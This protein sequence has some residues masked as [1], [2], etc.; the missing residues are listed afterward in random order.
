MAVLRQARSSHRLRRASLRACALLALLAMVCVAH[1]QVSRPLGARGSMGLGNRNGDFF[2]EQDDLQVKVPG[3]YARI[4]RDFDGDEWTFNRQWSGLGNPSHN[5]AKYPSLGTF[6]T[7][8]SIDG[9]RTCDGT[10][11]AGT[12]SAGASVMMPGDISI[13]TVRIP[14]D[15]LMGRQ[16]DGSPAP[17]LG[18]QQSIARKGVGF[19]RSSDGLSFVSADHPR[20]VVRKQSVLVLPASNGPDAH[21]APGRPGQGGLS[22]TPINGYRW[23][24]RSGEWIEYDNFGRITSYGDRNDARVWMQYGGHGQIERVLD[25]NGRTVFTLLYKDGGK[26]ITEARDHT[27]A[28]GSIRRVQYQYDGDGRLRTVVDAR[29]H[30]TT[31]DYGKRDGS[32]IS[33]DSSG[34]PGATA[35]SGTSSGSGSAMVLPVDLRFQIVKVTDAEGRATQI[36]YDVTKRAARITAPDGG[37]T[38]FEYGYDRLKSEFSIAIK[39]PQTEAGRRI[40]TLKFDKEGRPVQR[41]VNGKTV[42]TTQGGDRAMTYVDE[43]GASTQVVRDNFDE[44]TRITYA[45]GSSKS[46]TYEAS[47]TDLR[48]FV[49]EVGATWK[50][51]YDNRGN[52]KTVRAA[53]DK[54][55]EQQTE[56]EYDARGDVEL[57]RRKGGPAADGSTEPDIEIRMTRDANGN[58]ETL[59][60]GENKLWTYEY[61]HQGNLTK[62]TNPLN[63]AWSYT[64]DAH[65]NLLTETDPN[66]HTVQYEYDKTDLNVAVTDARN[67]TTRFGYDAAGRDATVV[68]P[69]GD[70]FTDQ[71]DKA[72]RL[73]ARRDA[74]GQSAA[75]SYDTSGRLIKSVDGENYATVLDYAEADGADKGARQPGKITYPTF[76]RLLRYDNRKRPTQQTDLLADDA[77]VMGT[78][79]DA[80]GRVKVLTDPNGHTRT[81]DYDGLGR[82]VQ[83]TNEIG[84]TVKLG[85]DRRNN[86]V[87]LTNPNGKVTR[88]AYDR[89]N[90]LVSETNP[91]NQATRYAYDDAGRLVELERPNGVKL[92]QQHDPA[93]RMEQRRA[94]RADGSIEQTHTFSW[95]A[96][97]NL[98]GWSTGPDSGV[99]VYDDADRMLSETVTIGGVALKRA[100]TY[101]PNDQVKTYTGPDG[102]TLAY[103]YD[104]LGQLTRLDIPGEGSITMT[105]RTWAAPKKIV[106]PGGTVQEMD[107]NGHLALTRLRVKTPDQR[108]VFELE[109]KFGK[110]RELKSRSSDAK[111]TRYDYD[112]AMRLIK[113]EPDFVAGTSETF[114][115][116]KAGNRTRH[117]RVSGTWEYDDANR[118]LRRG[119]VTYDY[120]AAGNLSRKVD[121]SASEPQ[122][123]TQYE[124]DGFNRLVR[125]RDGADGVIATYTYDPFDNRLSKEVFGPGAA[126]SGASPGKTLFLHGEEGLLA[127]TQTDGAVIRSYGWDQ[128]STYSTYPLF[129]RA[130]ADY[131]YYH[132]DHLGT[133]WRVTNRAGVVVWAASD[134]EAY[135]LATI[136]SGSSILQPWRFPGQYFDEE[137]ALHYNLRRFY[138]AASGRYI[139]E[140]PL[141]FSGGGNFY[142]YASNTPLNAIDPTGELPFLVP[143]AWNLGRAAAGRYITCVLECAVVDSISDLINNPCDVDVSDCFK[144]CLWSLLPIPG[145]CKKLA[146][147]WGGIQGFLNTFNSFPADTLV[148]TPKGLFPI[149][150]LRPGDEVLAYEEWSGQRKAHEI[151]DVVLS[152][153]T[154]ELVIVTL[155]SGQIFQVTAG[156]P[157]LSSEGWKSASSLTI[158]AKLK[159][160]R[161][162]DEG[163][164]SVVAQLSRSTVV[165]EVYN[166]E[167]EGAHTYAI[168]ESELVVHNGIVYCRTRKGSD[169]KYYGK[170]DDEENYKKRQQAHR[171]KFKDDEVEFEKVYEGPETGKDIERIEQDFI[172]AGGGPTN[173]SNPNGGLE[174]SRNNFRKGRR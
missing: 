56:Y 103:T 161:K 173:R 31:F 160:I 157:F 45:D 33:P 32:T 117:S 154:Q 18:N 70:T 128:E 172:D 119:N 133:P 127:E 84:A 2:V 132:N 22:T 136:A 62:A 38:D 40:D 158:G 142:T 26:F 39:Y 14:N 8:T 101:H 99:L 95:D 78:A 114:S 121:A 120:D 88:M 72:G 150:G 124:Y 92:T 76:Q 83:A 51:G 112:E 34:S 153:A 130:G 42:M 69:Y 24:D 166:L 144:D 87:S 138:D 156:H 57:V 174:N 170:A 113:A 81:H 145:A 55:E 15:P 17:D 5:S 102:V 71:Y 107:R 106:L 129:Q 131:F 54:P 141:G 149:S 96:A 29:G 90:L 47:A 46:Y 165:V 53:A 115:I 48:E 66:Q 135:G 94:Y 108:I 11:S 86:L 19:T 75:L 65:G 125:V 162:G 169:K 68:N 63:R 126:R 79:Y 30:S 139:S 98:T 164:W 50:Y 28:N 123:T 159:S 4:N 134:Y 35:G 152:R 163:E 148:A 85:Y 60:D 58:V 118:L 59:R 16:A 105:E 12:Y 25:D 36:G 116:D 82:L 137:T 151:S 10:A 43:R 171:R 167:V 146:A 23:T 67:H 6:F 49:D 52:L 77:M 41:E 74:S 168:G 37:Q 91:N 27:P 104:K 64:Y 93:G 80:K 7:C 143:L 110:M 9:V 100:Y 155:S 89:R 147:L 61:D 122:R 20:Y 109:N 3:G 140:D 111:L 97:D 73:T 21:P 44:I 13:Q 1:A